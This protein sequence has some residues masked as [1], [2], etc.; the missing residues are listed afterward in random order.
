MKQTRWY[1][2][3][4]VSFNV[5]NW[6]AETDLTRSESQQNWELSATWEMQWQDYRPGSLLSTT[7]ERH[8]LLTWRPEPRWQLP[9]DLPKEPTQSAVQVAGRK[10]TFPW[11]APTYL[12]FDGFKSEKVECFI[13]FSQKLILILW[14]PTQCADTKWTLSDC[15]SLLV[16]AFRKSVLGVNGTMAWQQRQGMML[17]REG[18]DTVGQGQT[19]V[20]A[21]GG[22][23]KF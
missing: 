14:S 19:R 5:R 4:S 17:W 8:L 22:I 13:V 1:I 3:F 6:T 21:G 16:R 23:F 12:V 7:L 2:T 10:Q 15:R 18:R 20:P 9:W 11:A